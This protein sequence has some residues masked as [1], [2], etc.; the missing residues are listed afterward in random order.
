[1]GAVSDTDQPPISPSEPR[2]AG[3][4]QMWVPCCDR[5][6][7][8]VWDETA[9]RRLLAMRGWG[10]KVMLSARKPDWYSVRLTTV[11]PSG[12]SSLSGRWL[13]G[14][15]DLC[16]LGLLAARRDYG[17]G[18]S[19]RLSDAGFGE[20]AGGTLYPALLRLE[21]GGLVDVSWQSSASGPRRK[22]FELTA[23][24]RAVRAQ[25]I[26]DWWQFRAGIDA[27]VAQPVLESEGGA[28]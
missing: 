1:M 8:A 21:R 15:L 3:P 6:R 10:S 4:C 5:L 27:A 20:V 11:T 28:Q 17:Y 16:L 14:F 23:A 18:L 26:Q 12:A 25:Q 24:G 19:Q 9:Q 22:Y 2:G 7:A 13:H